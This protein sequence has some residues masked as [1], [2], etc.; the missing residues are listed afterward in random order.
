MLS[1]SHSFADSDWSSVAPP[2]VSSSW[3]LHGVHF[4]SAGEGWATGIDYRNHSGILLHYSSGTWSSIALPF[5]SSDW[6]LK[7]VHLISAGEGWAVGGDNSKHRGVLLHCSG[8]DLEFCCPTFGEFR[9]VSQ[10][11]SP[12]LSR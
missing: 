8:G 2:S 11:C 10:Q 4:I 5:V 9:L 3:S 1:V 7:G 6:S 12:Y